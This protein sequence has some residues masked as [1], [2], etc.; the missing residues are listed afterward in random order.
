MAR[1][2]EDV[3]IGMMRAAARLDMSEVL[4][5]ITVP[6]LVLASAD[7]RVQKIHATRDWQRIIAGS[8]LRVLPGDSPHLAATAPDTCAAL[9]LAFVARIAGGSHVS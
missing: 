5:R 9:V 3:C 4:P 7:S 8:E 6:T 2:N 1:S